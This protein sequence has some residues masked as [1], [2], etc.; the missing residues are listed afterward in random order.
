MDAHESRWNLEHR[1][2]SLNPSI[3]PIISAKVIGSVLPVSRPEASMC[4]NFPLFYF[5][6]P[7]LCIVIPALLGQMSS[8]TANNAQF[9]TTDLFHHQCFLWCR[10]WVLQFGFKISM[11]MHCQVV[12]MV[13]SH[14]CSAGVL[15]AFGSIQGGENFCLNPNTSCLALWSSLTNLIIWFKYSIFLS[16]FCGFTLRN[17]DNFEYITASDTALKNHF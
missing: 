16:L 9:T 10:F 13:S 7:V 2:T 15:N 3:L 14:E 8:S 6:W 1:N 12:T 5:F 17:C 11:S 4:L